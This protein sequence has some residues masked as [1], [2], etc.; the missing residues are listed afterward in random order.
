MLLAEVWKDVLE[1]EEVGIHDNFY[2]LGGDSI[3]AIQVAAKLY[4]H[5]L[6][7]DTK[8]LMMNPTISTLAPVIAFIEQECDQGSCK[9]KCHCPLF[10]IGSSINNSRPC[11]NGISR[12]C[13][14]IRRGMTKTFCRRY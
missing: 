2:L 8:D 3:K 14:T 7:M 4:G 9:E 5:Q 13:Y 1:V 11:I 10:S 12:F 6:R